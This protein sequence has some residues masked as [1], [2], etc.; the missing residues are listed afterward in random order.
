MKVLITGGSGYI[1]QALV[2][3]YAKE[4]YTVL[5][6]YNTNHDV[7]QRLADSLIA[8]GYD[9]HLFCADLTDYN[10]IDK[11]MKD[12]IAKFKKIDVVVNNAAVSLYGMIQDTTSQQ[13]DRCFAVNCRA[14]YFVTQQALNNMLKFDSGS[15]V[16][17]SSIW[18]LQGASCESVYAMTKHALV[19][20]TRSLAQELED[21]NICINCVCPPIVLGGMSSN[22]SQQDICQFDSQH[23]TQAITASKLA[24]IVY[25]LSTSGESGLITDKMEV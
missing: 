15:I 21:T 20:L 14:A 17:M 16:L 4:G 22:L 1:G 5:L 11:M 7:A 18:G 25:A 12:I 19:G 6:H 24:D 23:G 9:I 2:T 8:S 3:K 10:Q 13:Y